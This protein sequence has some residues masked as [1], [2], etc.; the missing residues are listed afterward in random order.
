MPLF[1]NL[2]FYAKKG[3]AAADLSDIINLL[4][5][6]RKRSLMRGKFPSGT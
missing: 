1:E 3:V 4:K 6:A 2:A 5:Y